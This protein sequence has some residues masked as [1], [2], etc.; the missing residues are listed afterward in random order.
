MMDDNTANLFNVI[1]LLDLLLRLPYLPC[2]AK[3]LETRYCP[4]LDP[5]LFA[6]IAHDF[7]LSCD[8]NIR[9]LCDT[10]DTLKVSAAEQENV[11]FDP[12]GSSGAGAYE[13]LDGSA[14]GQSMSHN[15]L[16]SLETNSMSLESD[17]P[18]LGLE[19]NGSAAKPA[20]VERSKISGGKT[21]NTS[22]IELVTGLS[23]EEK[24]LY[25]NEMFPFIGQ[26]T[27]THTLSKCDED[28]DR[29]MDVLLN[30]A[31]FNDQTPDLENKVSIPK[32]VDGFESNSNAG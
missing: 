3:E 28:V 29:A 31:F 23:L 24:A 1:T 7:D 20:T 9:R 19:Q 18:S 4:P 14:S 8:R 15:T 10:L 16:K 26:Y 21:P 22:L 11:P 5:A 12:S 32:G 2:D 13:K 27:V 6:A 25:L 17:L 30:L